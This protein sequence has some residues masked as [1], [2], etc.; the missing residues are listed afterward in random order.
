[1]SAITMNF[2]AQKAS[3]FSCNWQAPPPLIHVISLSTSSAPSI[4]MSICIFEKLEIYDTKVICLYSYHI[5]ML[6]TVVFFLPKWTFPNR[7]P[8]NY[9]CS[10]AVSPFW[11]NFRYSVLCCVC[12]IKLFLMVYLKGWW[13]AHNVQVLLFNLFS[14]Y[15]FDK[16][17]RSNFRV[18]SYAYKMS[19]PSALRHT[20][21]CYRCRFQLLERS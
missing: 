12:C 20:Q 21:W 9:I 18:F 7:T 19:Y 8:S 13:N 10:V 17:E 2:L 16:L 4:V 5:G 1:M 6:E 3:S 15:V 11:Q 14:F